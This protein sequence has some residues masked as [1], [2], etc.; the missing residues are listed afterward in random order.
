MH[1]TYKALSTEPELFGAPFKVVVFGEFGFIFIAIMIL[2]LPVFMA[3]PSLLL[4][5]IYAVIQTRE[6]PDWHKVLFIRGR[7]FSKN[8]KFKETEVTYSA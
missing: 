3:L 4:F 7:Y 1:K 8:R 6:D 5:H 2:E